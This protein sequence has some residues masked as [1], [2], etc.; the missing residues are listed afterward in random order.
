MCIILSIISSGIL[1]LRASHVPYLT[2]VFNAHVSSALHYLVESTN[3]YSLLSLVPNT[4][5]GLPP[6]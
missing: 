3:R 1:F 2:L 4:Y 6:V 5:K